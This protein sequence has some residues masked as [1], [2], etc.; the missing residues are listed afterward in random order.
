MY[1]CPWFVF[2]QIEVNGSQSWE[3]IANVN[4]RGINVGYEIPIKE[5]FGVK[6]QFAYKCLCSYYEFTGTDFTNQR[7]ELHTT[8]YYKI[9]NNTTYQLIPNIGLNIRYSNWEAQMREPLDTFPIRQ[10][11]T[12]IRNERL[13]VASQKGVDYAQ[14]DFI[15]LG[16]TAQI[17]NRFKL[18]DKFNLNVTPFIEFDY[19]RDQANGGGYLGLY[20]NMNK[21]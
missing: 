9:I 11:G 17:Q 6:P 5:R 2:S 1:I 4:G 8:A 10:Y 16:F 20:Y 19:D 12:Y 14:V 18:S 13:A 15:T 21:R 7:A 3:G